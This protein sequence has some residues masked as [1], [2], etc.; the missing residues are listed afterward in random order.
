[1]TYYNKYYIEYLITVFLISYSNFYILI[2]KAYTL[3]FD[4]FAGS[5][6]HIQCICI[7]RG[8]L[9]NYLKVL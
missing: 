8:A 1:M 6:L 5:P 3:I 7:W 2:L 4:T 9:T